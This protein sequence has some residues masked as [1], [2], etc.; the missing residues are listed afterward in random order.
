MLN[1]TAILKLSLHIIHYFV[2]PF[3]KNLTG[4]DLNIIKLIDKIH[5]QEFVFLL[6][7]IML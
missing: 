5:S 2:D 7:V 1:R 3:Y 4:V 6:K